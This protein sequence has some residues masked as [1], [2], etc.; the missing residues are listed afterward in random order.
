MLF[1]QKFT[2]IFR[3]DIEYFYYVKFLTLKT[4]LKLM[5]KGSFKKI[6]LNLYK[7]GIL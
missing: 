7:S 3:R 5:I 4:V 2:I 6:F 1:E